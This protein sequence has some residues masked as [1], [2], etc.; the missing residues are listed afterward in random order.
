MTVYALLNNKMTRATTK[1]SACFGGSKY[2]ILASGFQSHRLPSGYSKVVSDNVVIIMERIL[3][4]EIKMR[5][6]SVAIGS[7]FSNHVGK[8][9]GIFANNNDCEH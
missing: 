8:S 3:A 6:A 1:R 7:F 5:V 4:Y 2:S 9:L